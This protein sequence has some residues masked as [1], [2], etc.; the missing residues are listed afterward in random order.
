[1]LRRLRIQ[2]GRLVEAT[3]A[4]GSVLV[5]TAPDEA[6]KRHLVDDLKI[7][8][9]TLNS[10]VD[11]DELARLEFEPDHV[12]LIFKHPKNYSSED[13]FLFKVA[14]A[15]L[16]LF[17]DRLVIVIADDSPV[18]EGRQF[19]RLRTL[20]DLILRIIYRSIFHYEEHLRVIN[21][22]SAEIEH[23]INTAMENKYLLNLFTLEK[24]L[25]YYLNA[26]NSNGKVL[27]RLKNS[28]AKV[29]FTPENVELLDDVLI[30]NGQCYEQANI[31]SQVLS[32]LMDARVSVVSNNLNVLMKTLTLVM[33]AIMVP[34]LVVSVF[35][36]NVNLPLPGEGAAWHFWL[37]VALAASSA[38]LV[39]FIWKYKKL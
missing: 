5:Y 15:G 39:G 13:D 11:P 10:A 26:I 20:Q 8:E 6:E 1:M 34:T 4:D 33:I 36:M 27:D 30:E 24:S 7:D 32:G 17:R 9:H 37:V 18:L 14:S 16:F 3:E 2:D 31:Y 12:A 25:V 19:T 22:I 38:V 21:S 23:Q 28:A 29:G 35:S